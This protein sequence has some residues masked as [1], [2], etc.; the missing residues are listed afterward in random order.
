[1]GIDPEDWRTYR[2]L[3]MGITPPV[4]D[5]MSAVQLDYLLAIDD[6]MAG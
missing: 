6:E 5:G 1:M 3:R 4:A 2:L